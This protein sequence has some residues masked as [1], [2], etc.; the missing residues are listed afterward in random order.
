[1][2][3]G[4]LYLIGDEGMLR[5]GTIFPLVAAPII[6]GVVIGLLVVIFSEFSNWIAL[7]VVITLILGPIFGEYRAR[8]LTRLARLGHDELASRKGALAVPWSSVEH[9]RLEGRRLTFR[10]ARG[11]ISATIERADAERLGQKASS[12][13]GGKFAEIPKGPPRFSRATKFLLLTA[14]LFLITEGITLAASLIPFFSGEQTHYTNLYNSVRQSLGPTIF[15]QWSAIFLNNVQVALTSFVPGFGSL[16]LG[17]SSYNTGRVIQ[18]AAIY[19][20]V[21]PTYFLIILF[22]LPH[23]WVE[24]VS[25]PLAGALGFYAFTWR[26]Q[27]FAEFSSW[28]TRASTKITLGFTSIAFLL[29]V[30]AALEVT[31][32]D[33]GIGALLLW[34]PVALVGI[35]AYLKLKSRIAAAFS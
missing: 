4:N 30:A 26:H 22:I 34:G 31:E 17:L 19:F 32:P 6:L 24:E 13:L 14:V 2:N 18:A 23:T 20:N 9:M 27:S 10:L 29:A 1:M 5:V 11:W 3:T 8:H 16:V 33:L 12:V 28:K 21:S 25:Y 35:Y 7:S 15:Q